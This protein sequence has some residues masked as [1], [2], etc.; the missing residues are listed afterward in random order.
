MIATNHSPDIVTN[1]ALS[2][3][4]I[5]ATIPYYIWTTHKRRHIAN[6]A[7][8]QRSLCRDEYPRAD[9]RALTGVTGARIFPLL[10]PGPPSWPG[11]EEE[12]VADTAIL[13]CGDPSASAAESSC[14]AGNVA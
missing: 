9:R 11:Q 7:P 4:T 10:P 1:V 3:R 2:L 14:D 13:A 12:T 8:R 5:F 6:P